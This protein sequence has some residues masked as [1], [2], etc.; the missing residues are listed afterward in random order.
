MPWI[1]YNQE[2]VYGTEFIIEFLEERLVGGQPGGDSEDAVG[3]RTTGVPAEM[4]C[5]LINLAMYCERIRRRFWPEWFV[6]LEDFRYDLTTEISDTPSKLPD[7]GLYSRTH[8][9]QETIYSHH[10]QL[11]HLSHLSHTP[12]PQEPPSPVSDPTGHSLYDSDMDTECSEI[13]QLKC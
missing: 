12:T 8:T 6:D 4:M 11:F 9:S 13:D 7:L 10:S 1:E 2:E 3:E 5:E